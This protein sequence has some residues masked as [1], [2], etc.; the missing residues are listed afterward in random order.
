M[1]SFLF[2]LCFGASSA[3]TSPSCLSVRKSWNRRQAL[4]AALPLITISSTFP[5]SAAADLLRPQPKGIKTVILESADIKLG[6]KVEDVSL[7]KEHKSYAVVQSVSQSGVAMTQGIVPGMIVLGQ[8]SASALVQRLQRGPYPY[9]VQ[10]YDASV[11]SEMESAALAL[12]QLKEEAQQP[13][14]VEP[15]LSPKGTGLVV[16]TKRKATDCSLKAR[17]GDTVTIVYEARVAS[18]GGPIYDS[19]ADRDGRPVTFRLGEGKAIP[20][21]D[22]GIGGMCQGEVREL[23]IPSALGYGRFGSEVFDVPGDVRLW[24]KVELLELVEGEKRFPFR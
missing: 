22:V 5:R 24:W 19:T 9:A 2:L 4:I 21:V 7:G 16:K 23:D 12:Q 6:V 10:F 13:V 11:E 15:A 14:F 3:L 17:S 8:P 20:G 18:P 1:Q